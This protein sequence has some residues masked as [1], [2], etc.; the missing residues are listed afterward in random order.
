MTSRL[1]GRRAV[2]LALIASW[3]LGC[4]STMPSPMTSSPDEV[5]TYRAA[6]ER[7]VADER[8]LRLGA[9]MALNANEQEA[10]RRLRKL[11]ADEL[12]RT[13][14]AFPPATSFLLART[15]LAY[16]QSP[17]F[18]LL[19]R[20][21]KGAVL[22]AHLSAMG[23][24][25]WI[26][27]RALAS[28]RSY[29]FMG[30]D[31]G[32]PR[33]A[34]RFADTAPAAG[35]L[36]L[37]ELRAEG[38]DPAVLE[39]RVL[40]ALTLGDEELTHADI[41]SEFAAIFARVGG[42][43]ADPEFSADHFDHVVENLVRDNVQY[44]EL[45]SFPVDDAWVAR[46]RRHDPA[47]DV[48][49]IPAAGRSMSRDQAARVLARV[50]EQRQALPNRVKGFDF[51]QEEDE[52]NTNLFYLE[53]LLAAR[54]AARQRGTDLPLYLHSGESNWADNDNLYDAILLGSRR[55]GHALALI[56]HPLLLQQIKA[57]DIA[58]EVCPLSNQI[59]DFVSDLRIHPAAHY[60]STSMP[61]VLSSDDPGIFQSSLT[62]DFYAAFMA[63]GL[64]LRALKQL[65]M[66]SL[67]YS[68]M[69]A[70]E[71]SRAMAVWQQRWASFVTWVNRTYP[72]A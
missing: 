38:E 19:R 3:P 62:H 55:I 16:E 70:E 47:F 31:P 26:V 52:G 53:E 29:V 30:D 36:R 60:V 14:D 7:M 42:L 56:R 25:R 34:L 43:F 49:F 17:L 28:S 15:R 4:A 23:D 44:L 66:N 10:D 27:K 12:T 2:L 68:A 20:M 13:R 5:A 40:R 45:R 67:R 6:R 9:G 22:H 64:D 8:G 61:M 33:G 37:S 59:L 71:R 57:R 69:T 41:W 1:M 21:P 24:F 51:V 11:Q 18:E 58:I 72:D 50:V 48:K 39:Q 63:W 35:W 65:A 46:A 54:R 32:T